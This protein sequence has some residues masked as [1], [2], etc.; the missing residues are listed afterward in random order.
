MIFGKHV[1]FI[2]NIR[3]AFCMSSSLSIA[4]IITTTVTCLKLVGKCISYNKI[5]VIVGV[6]KAIKII[7]TEY[8]NSK[9]D[10]SC[11]KLG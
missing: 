9:G 8:T 11:Q 6:Q 10:C 4:D 3:D 1:H 7:F 2:P 5:L